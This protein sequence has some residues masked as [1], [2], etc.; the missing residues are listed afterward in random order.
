[1]GLEALIAMEE[2][3]AFARHVGTTILLL[4]E[5]VNTYFENL[6]QY[7]PP[8]LRLSLSLLSSLTSGTR[9]GI[10]A[11]GFVFATGS[12]QASAKHFI[13]SKHSKKY[14]CIPYQD[15][16]NIIGS[17]VSI[18]LNLILKTAEFFFRKLI[19]IEYAYPP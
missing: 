11:D 10:K 13:Q 9:Q 19:K 17:S 3:I 12:I 2:G 18:T 14:A 7:A 16:F 4:P 15:T 6:E 8:A 1:M 5:S